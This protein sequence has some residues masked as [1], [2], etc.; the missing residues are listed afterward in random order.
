MVF[1]KLD[2]ISTGKN[3]NRF[4]GDIH[5]TRYDYFQI[6]K[7]FGKLFFRQLQE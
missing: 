3:L 1:R 4:F 7:D 5:S 6:T 2:S